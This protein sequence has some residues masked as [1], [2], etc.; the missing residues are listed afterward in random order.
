[1]ELLTL[2]VHN[3]Q[4][5]EELQERMAQALQQLHN[6]YDSGLRVSILKHA[7]IAE[8]KVKAMLSGFQLHR[9]S[10]PVYAC[11]S[12]ALSEYILT[13]EE[14]NILRG[15]IQKQCGQK[16]VDLTAIE[17]YC[18]QV[19]NGNTNNTLPSETS[20]IRRK[21]KISGLLHAYMQLNSTLDVH[22]FIRFRLRDYMTELQET[23][24]YALDEYMMEQQYQEF[25]SLLKYFVYIQEAKI[26]VVHLIHKGGHEFH[27]LNEHLEPIDVNDGDCAM[28]LELI[29]KDINFEDM[30]VSTLITVSP[31]QIYIHTREAEAPIIKTIM[32]IFENRS[33]V[34]TYCRIC[35]GLL[36]EI[37]AHDQL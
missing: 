29:D 2:F 31:A 1:M 28:T 33:T 19:L 7:A 25:I 21:Q 9:D 35:H 23:L 12:D 30:I 34:C 10:E 15:L 8:I 36:G 24:D 5:A 14:L 11:L 3:H 22:G 27:I 13:T 16:A 6:P 32:Q 26:P 17:N 18:M 4:A 20:R 37:K